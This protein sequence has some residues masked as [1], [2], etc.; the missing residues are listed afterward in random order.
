M[1]TVLGDGICAPIFRVHV[2]IGSQRGGPL[3]SSD[4]ETGMLLQGNVAVDP[5]RILEW[6]SPQDLLW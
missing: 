1:L 2:E 3:T 4:S 5:G 6:F